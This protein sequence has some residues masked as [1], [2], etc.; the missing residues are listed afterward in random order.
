MSE[1]PLWAVSDPLVSEA[2]CLLTP[3]F[4]RLARVASASL[5]AGPG[6][7]RLWALEHGLHGQLSGRPGE[8]GGPEG[9]SLS[10]RRLLWEMELH[11]CP[12]VPGGEQQ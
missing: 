2:G 10:L 4:T 1:F 12:V 6:R 11:P 3:T 8:G 7:Q 5:S 9:G